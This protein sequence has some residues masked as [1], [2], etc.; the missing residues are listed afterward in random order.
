MEF[1]YSLEF[2]TLAIVVAI[3]IVGLLCRP[4]NLAPARSYICALKNY[5]SCDEEKESIKV[6]VNGTTL[7]LVRYG[8][9]L[10]LEESAHLVCN[11]NGDKI[12]I[13]EKKSETKMSG[14]ERPAECEAEL[15]FLKRGKYAVRYESDIT[16][17]W[18]TFTLIVSDSFTT[19]KE[20]KL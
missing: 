18:C 20:L 2:Y 12:E 3:V 6:F 17:K 11:V 1:F 9:M 10:R 8:I 13:K 5:Y 15:S 19:H 14:E 16:G 7:S 4:S